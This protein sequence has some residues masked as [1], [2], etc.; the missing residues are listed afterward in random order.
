VSED[1]IRAGDFGVDAV[2]GWQPGLGIADAALLGL[3]YLRARATS[4]ADAEYLEDV[5]GERALLN[6]LAS[7]SGLLAGRDAHT[8]A[9]F[10]KAIAPLR[11]WLLRCE[12]AGF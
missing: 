8:P 6:G 12:A 5:V 3:S 10:E 11:E 1:E 2:P 7:L 4:S 9:E